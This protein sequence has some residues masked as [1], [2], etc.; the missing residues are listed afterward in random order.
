MA[1][2]AKLS[3]RPENPYEKFQKYGLESLSDQELLAI[4]IRNGTKTHDALEIAQEILAVHEGGLLNLFQLEAGDLSALD[5]IGF[6]KAM[7]LKCIAELATRMTRQARRD[8]VCLKS[9]ASVA[10]YF[11]ESLRH[12]VKE[13][14]V[15]CLF[16]AKCHLITDETVTIG[17]LDMT[18]FSARDIFSFAIR[19]HACY[20][21][22][23]HNH[24]SGDPTPSSED[25]MATK[26]IDHA[27]V[28]LGIP[29]MDHIIIGDNSYYSFKENGLLPGRN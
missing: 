7:E 26:K 13:R 4:V 17:T 22:V 6:V 5:G 8:M 14:L 24:P 29:L 28:L 11:M 19:F 9:A 16:D 27:G 20:I 3:L 21:I 25:H 23:L 2:R 15:V 1:G 12:Q 18:L 10:D